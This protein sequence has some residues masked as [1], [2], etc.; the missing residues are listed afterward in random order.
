[1]TYLVCK[2]KD[3]G[4]LFITT[5]S[6]REAML[7]VLQGLGQPIDSIVLKSFPNNTLAIL[8]K[9]DMEDIDKRLNTICK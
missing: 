7:S 3:D 9:K 8:Y 2:N 4:K 5:R 1:M 6:S